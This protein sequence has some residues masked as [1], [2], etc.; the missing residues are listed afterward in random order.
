MG[1]FKG[2]KKCI[3]CNNPATFWMGHIHTKTG[4]ITAGFCSDDCQIKA[5]VERNLKE[6]CNDTGHGCYGRRINVK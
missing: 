5:W 2:T 3:I 4:E 1:V 6:T